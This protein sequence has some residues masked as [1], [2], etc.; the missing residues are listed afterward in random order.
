MQTA[1]TFSHIFE[2]FRVTLFSIKLHCIKQEFQNI[3]RFT[4]SRAFKAT[5]YV[6]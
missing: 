5:Y 6:V 3:F 1:N 4:R 2:S